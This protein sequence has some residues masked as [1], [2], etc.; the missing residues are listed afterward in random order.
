MS[1]AAECVCLEHGPKRPDIA[2]ERNI[3]RDEAEGRFADVTLVRCARCRRLWLRHFYEI[4]AFSESGRWAE[5][6]I[7]E[8][9]AATIR[10][11]AAYSFIQA[12][13]FRVI[14]GSFYGGESRRIGTP[15]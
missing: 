15:I 1:V 4:E 5:A 7:D 2:E 6:L 3:G 10:P 12:A 8:L 9:A 14:G 11:E 13:P